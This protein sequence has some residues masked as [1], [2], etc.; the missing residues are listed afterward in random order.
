MLIGVTFT[1]ITLNWAHSTVS[2][3][4]D[5]TKREIYQ[6]LKLADSQINSTINAEFAK[7]YEASAEEP[8]QKTRGISDVELWH[9]DSVAHRLKLGDSKES[10]N[11]NLIIQKPR[12]ELSGSEIVVSAW[13]QLAAKTSIGKDRKNLLNYANMWLFKESSEIGFTCPITSDSGDVTGVAFCWIPRASIE[14]FLPPN[15]FLVDPRSSSVLGMDLAH[16]SDDSKDKLFHG[17]IVPDGLFSASKKIQQP[18]E[19]SNWKLW[20]NHPVSEVWSRPEVRQAMNFPAILVTFVWLMVWFLVQSGKKVRNRQRRLIGSLV[21]KVIWITNETGQIDYVLGKITSYLGWKE[22]DY[23]NVDIALFVHP[24]DREAIITAISNAKPSAVS[25]EIIEVRFENKDRE[26]RWY[27][28]TIAN[29]T[30]VPEINGVVVTAHDI[31]LR[32]HATDHILA[33]KRAAE[34]ANEA[35]SDFLSRM[36][37]ELRTPLN[38]ILGFGQLLEMEAIS[39]RQA[40]NVG[41]ILIA[42]RHLLNLVN[43]ILDIARIETRKVNLSV[44][45]VNLLEVIQ[46]SLTLLGPLA[47]KSNVHLEVVGQ[48]IPD[49]W[50][51]RQRIKQVILNLVSNGI[52]YN[53]SGGHVTVSFSHSE[54]GLRLKVSDNGIGIESHY[55]ERVFTPFDRLGSDN[56]QVEGSGLG[57]AL[58]KTLVEAMGAKLEVYSEYGK[59]SVFT[60]DFSPCSI[61]QQESDIQEPVE[62]FD[63]GDV[64]DFRILLIEDNVVNLRYVSKVVQKLPGVAL[65]SAKEGGIGIEM[66]RLH[67][68]DLILLDLDLPDLHGR[69]VLK[70]LKA[71][72]KTSQLRIIVMSAETNPHIVEEILRLG[73]NQF[74]TKPVDVNSLIDM[75]SEERNAA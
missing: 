26:Y 59:G 14:H 35:K 24:E 37:H 72:E 5:Q 36:S 47:T 25:D 61:V 34:K 42:G 63:L 39:D 10:V 11:S 12:G 44:E 60:I 28:V 69:D 23:L 7:L 50:S 13:Q 56:A 46:E 52:K 19:F 31:E 70:A 43:D 62:K 49:V 32:K 54:D 65:I 64:N 22:V 38:A 55:L 71:D 68:P 20:C 48:E 8:G 33:S 6:D 58:S 17:E 16:L 51:D 66:A 53:R 1:V 40:E 67:N 41:Q 4:R 3:L 27:E 29:M 57:L 30:D 75:F 15:T 74:V 2:T 18:M 9:Y 73:A 45:K 21:R